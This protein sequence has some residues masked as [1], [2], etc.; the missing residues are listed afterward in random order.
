MIGQSYIKDL[1]IL[2]V[3]V[4]VSVNAVSR[5]KALE[6]PRYKIRTTDRE[7]FEWFIQSSFFS[8]NTISVMKIDAEIAKYIINH[9]TDKRIPVLVIYD[10]M[11]INSIYKGDLKTVMQTACREIPLGLFN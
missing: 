10:R 2:K 1:S 7:E 3:I 6:A 5:T 9:F 8:S 11:L 4:L